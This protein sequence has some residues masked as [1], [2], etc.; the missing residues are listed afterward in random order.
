[1]Y[2]PNFFVRKEMLHSRTKEFVRTCAPKP[3]L[4][5]LEIHSARLC[6]LGRNDTK[7]ACA[8]TPNKPTFAMVLHGGTLLSL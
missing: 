1:M 4:A 2:T 8:N 3:L 7:G 6:W 5:V